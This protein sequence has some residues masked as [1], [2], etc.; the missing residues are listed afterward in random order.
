ML[1]RIG[2]LRSLTNRIGPACVFSVFGLLITAVGTRAALVA[3]SG[4]VVIALALSALAN[5]RAN[6]GATQDQT[7]R[8][9]QMAKH[10][11]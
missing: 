8:G 11:K 9:L 1:G 5:L 6:I 7:Q 2:A 10:A 3:I 4:A